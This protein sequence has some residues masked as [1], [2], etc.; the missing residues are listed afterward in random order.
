MKPDHRVHQQ[1]PVAARHRVGAR[2]AGLLVDAVVRVG[3]E[4]A[5]LPRFEVHDVLAAPQLAR[6]LARLVEHREIH[7]EGRV[8]R[9]RPGDRL[10]HQVDGRAAAQRLH[11]RRHVR[12]HADLRRD[13]VALAD[14][15][16]HA[17]QRLDGGDAVAW[18]G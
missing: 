10:K 14:A 12:Q 9:L 15:V 2:L 3:R 18:P 7:A 6:R 8:G 16:E 5:S 11:L 17:E 13:V 1:R 4:R